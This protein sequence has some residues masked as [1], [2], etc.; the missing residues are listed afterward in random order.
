[1]LIPKNA[2]GRSGARDARPPLKGRTPPTPRS[3]APSAP[4]P[5]L[6]DYADDI[7][8]HPDDLYTPVDPVWWREYLQ[9]A[10]MAGGV[11]LMGMAR[12]SARR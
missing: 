12:E 9:R 4:P 5:P 11:G 10:L 6:E 7:R 3:S 8:M 2:A 1:M